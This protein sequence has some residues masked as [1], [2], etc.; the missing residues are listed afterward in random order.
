MLRMALPKE[1][2]ERAAVEAKGGPTEEGVWSNWE[3]RQLVE[4]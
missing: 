4:L 1:G 3:M 2:S